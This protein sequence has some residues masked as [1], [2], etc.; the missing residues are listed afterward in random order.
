MRLLRRWP[1]ADRFPLVESKFGRILELCE[2]KEVLDCG[3]IGDVAET[4]E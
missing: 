3:C 1:P 2:G 4:P